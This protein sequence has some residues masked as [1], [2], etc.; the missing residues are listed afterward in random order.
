MIINQISYKKKFV[1]SSV[2]S[3]DI[4]YNKIAYG[5]TGKIVGNAP[6]DIDSIGD[7]TNQYYKFL[8]APLKLTTKNGYSGL[9]VEEINDPKSYSI[10]MLN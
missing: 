6:I 9:L 4:L 10:Q 3:K 7:E 5:A 2:T 8:K 1:D